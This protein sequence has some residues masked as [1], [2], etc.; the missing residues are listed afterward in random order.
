PS[1]AAQPAGAR[2]DR[3]LSVQIS[4]AHTLLATC[5][6]PVRYWVRTRRATLAW[7]AGG[8]GAGAGGGVRAGGMGG[9]LAGS[10][11]S[12]DREVRIPRIR[13]NDIW[14]GELGGRGR[15]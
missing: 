4:H 1:D 6:W 14:P 10:A 7:S 5:G 15:G 9:R 3:D 11:P 2:H 13:K 8:G 12:R